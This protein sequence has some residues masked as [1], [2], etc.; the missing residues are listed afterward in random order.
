[1]K[2]DSTKGVPQYNNVPLC[3]YLF[4]HSFIYLIYLEREGREKETERNTNVR[5]KHQLVAFCTC[6]DQEGTTT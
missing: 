6:P 3:I 4:I 1:M 5:E 2:Y